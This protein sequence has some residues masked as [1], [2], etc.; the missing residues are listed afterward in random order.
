MSVTY[1]EVETHVLEAAMEKRGKAYG[2]KQPRAFGFRGA[3]ELTQAKRIQAVALQ[4]YKKYG[5]NPIAIHNAV[6]KKRA[7]ISG[8]AP[9]LVILLPFI[10]QFIQAV[11]PL[12]IQALIDWINSLPST[13]RAS[14]V[15]GLQHTAE[16]VWK[17]DD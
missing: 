12:L 3:S 6:F 17:M 11:A 16:I 7:Q 9:I 10:V 2:S 5:N 13:V 1:A 4:A 14:T 8:F 15:G